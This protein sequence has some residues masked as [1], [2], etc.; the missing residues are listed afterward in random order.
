MTATFSSEIL[1]SYG[2]WVKTGGIDLERFRN[3]PVLT[4]NHQTHELPVGKVINIRIED[5]RLVGEVDFDIKDA[6][7]LELKRK[8]DEGYMSGFSIGIIPKVYSE[9][10][11]DIK[12]GQQY[13]TV[14][15][16]ELLEIAAVTIP[17]NSDAVRMYNQSGEVIEMAENMNLHFST[18]KNKKLMLKVLILLGLSPTASEEEAVLAIEKKRCRN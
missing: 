16:C 12:M 8:Y 9:D 7:G 4:Y 13:Q 11:N 14:V 1:N 2:F 18:Y 6:R 5:N 10:K 15:A 17:S 3:N